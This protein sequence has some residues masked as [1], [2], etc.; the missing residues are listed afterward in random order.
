MRSG[1]ANIK[2]GNT[3]VRQLATNTAADLRTQNQPVPRY[4]SPEVNEL[5]VYEEAFPV[6]T[7]RP[8][9]LERRDASAVA[10]WAAAYWS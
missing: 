10:R 8:A 6:L 1:S 5:N 2:I 3:A 4:L 7:L 9:A